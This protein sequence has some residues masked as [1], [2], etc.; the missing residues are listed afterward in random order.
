MTTQTCPLREASGGY[1]LSLSKIVQLLPR[2]V[3][4][5]DT[6]ISVDVF[7]NSEQF[8]CSTFTTVAMA[9][10]DATGTPDTVRTTQTVFDIVEYVKEQD[11]T[12]ITEAADAIGCAKSTAHRHLST[13]HELGYIV[14]DSEGYHVG[15]RFLDLGQHARKRLQGYELVQE[16][17]EELAN[18]TGE[19]AQFLVEEHGEA[20]YIHRTFGEHAIRTDP[21]IGSRIPLHATAAGKSILANMNARKRNNIIEQTDFNPIT[22]ATIMDPEQLR[23]ELQTI[24][25]QGYSFNQEENLEGLHAVGVPVKGPDGGVIGALSVSGPTHRLRD[26]RLNEGLPKLL[27]G[28][29]NELE[30]NVAHL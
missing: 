5:S 14:V 23:D 19:R 9:S 20:V 28:T 29:A 4:I 12:T 25:E 30:L 7:R 3:K 22:D 8:Y 15:L 11:G 18:Q 24:Q 21:G 6:V 1:Q 26:E 27:L 17:V 16:K 2:V 13:L 10:N